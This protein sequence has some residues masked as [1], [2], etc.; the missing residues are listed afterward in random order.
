MK[1][2]T[3]IFQVIF[4]IIVYEVHCTISLEMFVFLIISLL[5]Y[6]GVEHACEK[7]HKVLPQ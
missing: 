7:V 3:I 4:V 5:V 6:D 1:A 2:R